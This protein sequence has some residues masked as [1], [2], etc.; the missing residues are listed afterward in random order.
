MKIR[1]CYFLIIIFVGPVNIHQTS[2]KVKTITSFKII[3]KVAVHEI[4]QEMQKA[5]MNDFK[6]ADKKRNVSFTMIAAALLLG[7]DPNPLSL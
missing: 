2:W 4:T 5:T 7:A 6:Q 1:L 3:Q